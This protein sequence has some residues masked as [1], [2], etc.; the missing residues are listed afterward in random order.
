MSQP[1]V[2]IA[3]TDPAIGLG[4]VYR[5]RALAAAFDG[6][7]LI[8]GVE[9]LDLAA[10]PPGALVILDSLHSG[11][12]PEAVALVRRL[13]AQGA[14]VAV[15]D[16][17]PPDHFPHDAPQEASPDWLITPYV[18]AGRLRPAPQDGAWLAGEAYAILP[19]AFAACP[20]F[21]PAS[22]RILVL[23]GGADP[24]GLSARLAGA[25]MDGVHPIDVVVGAHFS[26]TLVAD[27]KALARRSRNL[28]LHHA[29]D[30]VLPL[31]E[32]ARLVIGRPG[33]IRYEAAALG[34]PALYLAEGDAYLEYFRA[35]RQAGYA[36]IYLSAEADG[37]ARFW[38]KIQEIASGAPGAL[39][40]RP[41]N[42]V[43]LN[44]AARLREAL[45]K[46]LAA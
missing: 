14:Q 9:T 1:V 28:S 44:G 27:L 32:G 5:C 8:E 25:L 40:V 31:Y 6:A 4:H 20:A 10:L 39:P 3:A 19:Q 7:R 16:S 38:K 11:A 45:I 36:D 34:R 17:M 2:I 42:G 30:S 24:S 13:K 33:L 46:R 12:A 15:I 37:E 21:D 23:C 26:S 35:F 22:D 18:G 29:P 43:D 41:P